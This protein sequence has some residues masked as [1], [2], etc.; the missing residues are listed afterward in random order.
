MTCPEHIP[1]VGH[2]VKGH[3]IWQYAVKVKLERFIIP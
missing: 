1:G 2:H 3:L